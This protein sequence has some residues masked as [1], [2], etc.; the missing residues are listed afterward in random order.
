MIEVMM[1]GV[2]DDGEQGMREAVIQ[3]RWMAM[4]ATLVKMRLEVETLEMEL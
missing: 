1:L 4:G 3:S 2:K